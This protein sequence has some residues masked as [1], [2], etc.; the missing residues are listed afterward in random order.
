[1]AA[2]HGP[3]RLLRVAQRAVQARRTRGARAVQLGPAGSSRQLIRVHV[4]TKWWARP[5]APFS[6]VFCQG[7]EL[8]SM[9]S[10]RNPVFDYF[11]FWFILH[12]YYYSFTL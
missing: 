4:P 8:T 9:C 12:L 6:G 10:A 2:A 11:V 1:M 5:G 7:W 3:R